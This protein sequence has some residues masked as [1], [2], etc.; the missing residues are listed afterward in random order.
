MLDLVRYPS[1]VGN[2][3]AYVSPQTSDGSR[4]PAIVWLVGGFANSIGP[5]AWEPAPRHD[6][7]SARAFREAGVVLMLPSLRGGNDNPGERETLY[8]EVDDVLAARDWL[9]RQPNVDPDRI[10]LGGHSTG[11]T[12]A[13]LVAETTDKFRAVIA[14][15][16]VAN[17]ASYS[18][19]RPLLA[20][21]HE[22]RVRSPIHFM[23]TI[24]TPTF[25]V[26]GS[27]SPNAGDVQQLASAA[28]GAPVKS[29]TI[30]GGSHFSILA[31]ITELLATKILADDIDLTDAGLNAAF[32]R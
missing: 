22:A 28:A 5:S 29:Y 17:A 23:E 3:A 16:P 25:I 8:G 19:H 27:D 26:E 32:A 15:G 20:N 24:R 7:Q 18:G 13:L 31:P 14:F 11:G 1:P 21:A 6:D 2:L 4:R 12:L 30:Q 10:Y 9:V